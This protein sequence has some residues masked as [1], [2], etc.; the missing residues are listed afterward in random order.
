MAFYN[1]NQKQP[2]QLVLFQSRLRLIIV[3][4]SIAFLGLLFRFLWL[5]ILKYEHFHSLANNNRLALAPVSA[6]RGNILDRNNLTLASNRLAYMVTLSPD[7]S[8]NDGDLFKELGQYFRLT[9][10]HIKEYHKN[11][12][13]TKSS[14]PLALRSNLTDQEVARFAANSFRFSGVY[15]ETE[16]I[17]HYPHGNTAS[18]A[19]GYIGSISKKDE[20]YI[21]RNNEASNYIGTKLIGQTGIE[22]VFE[23]DLHGKSGF[24]QIEVSASGR[25][26]QVLSLEPAISGKNIQLTLDYHLQK[27]AEDAFGERRG[28]LVA[29]DPNTGEILTFVSMPNFAPELFAQ[30]ISAPAWNALNQ[31]PQKPLSNRTL[32]GTYAPG[33]TIK[34]FMALAAL[35]YKIRTPEENHFDLGYFAFGNRVFRDFAEREPGNINLH[36]SIIKSSDT[37]YYSLAAELGIDSISKFLSQFGFGQKTGVELI[38][39]NAGILPSREW[40]KKNTKERRWH[41][42]ETIPIGIGQGYHSYTMLQLARATAALANGGFLLPLH[43][44]IP[45]DTISREKYRINIPQKHLNIVRNAMIDVTKPGGTAAMAFARSSYE[46]AGKTGTVQLFSLGADEEYDEETLPDHLK[47]HSLFIAFAPAKKPTI[48]LAVI[49]E[50]GGFGSVSAAPIARKVID[51]HLIK[52]AQI[53]SSKKQASQEAALLSSLSAQQIVSLP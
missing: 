23:F 52:P 19:L 20:A 25:P 3:V 50:N 8:S 49:V 6:I 37:Y 16:Y 34:P 2:N 22:R 28:S 17:R 9:D 13:K 21:R 47:D 33:S 1:K 7:A 24:K 43:L 18:H 39:E 48:A 46:T 38:G 35:H 5:Q 12:R 29:L 53:N 31:D 11:R 30:G 44:T 4:I 26:I 10:H 51:A 40:K 45:T 42:G 36:D 32:S 15:L 27:I 41:K 14:A